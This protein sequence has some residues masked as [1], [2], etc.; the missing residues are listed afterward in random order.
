MARV[1]AL[2]VDLGGSLSP[3]EA[4]LLHRG[5][6]TLPLRVARANST[7]LAVAA[8]LHGHPALGR[9]HYPGLPS[10]RDHALATKLFDSGRYGGIVTVDVAGG[11]EAALAFC[12]RLQLAQNA[13]S[14]AGTH[15]VVSHVAS[16]T[17]RQLDDAALAAGGMSPGSVRISLGLEDTDDLVADLT[18]ALG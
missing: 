4:F 8:A 13:T 10:H 18:Q 7:A 9:V 5:I 12:D 15:T 2:R 3:D 17:H 11:R 1:R 6:A 16:T 14:L